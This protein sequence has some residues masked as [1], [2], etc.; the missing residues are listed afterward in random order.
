[1]LLAFGTFTNSFWEKENS[2][3]SQKK[4]MK[5][6]ATETSREHMYPVYVVF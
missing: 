1:M 2:E 3:I 4:E 5:E 6:D